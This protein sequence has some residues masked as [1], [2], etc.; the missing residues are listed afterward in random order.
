MGWPWLIEATGEL[1]DAIVAYARPR[2][3]FSDDD[4]I[5]REDGKVGE[6][7]EKAIGRIRNKAYLRF[8]SAVHG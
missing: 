4:S 3:A 5:G 6:N 2:D 1:E 7:L 8:T